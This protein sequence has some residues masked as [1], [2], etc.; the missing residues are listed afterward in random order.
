MATVL[1][2]GQIS[3]AGY[4]IHWPDLD[5][6]LSTEGLLRGAPAAAESVRTQMPDLPD[7]VIFGYPQMWEEVDQK[8]HDF[9]TI[10]PKLNDALNRLVNAAYDPITKPQKA[11]LNLATLSMIS[12]LE[13]VT[14]V[15]N[16][17][18]QGGLKILRSMLE[19]GINA[20]YLR[21]NPGE[22][23]DFI[24]WYWI[25]HY[26][27]LNYIRDHMP[28][29]YAEL[30][31]ENI[32][33]SEAEYNRVKPR[34]E[35]ETRPGRQKL[36]DSWCSLNLADRATR[37]DFTEE[38]KLIYPLTSRL[39]HGSLAGM[40]LHYDPDE[41][42]HRLAV[43]PSLEW[44]GETLICGHGIALRMANTFSQAFGVESNPPYAELERDYKT[45]WAK[46]KKEIP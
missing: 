6:D 23:D 17:L 35:Y 39:F 29:A 45:V 1:R 31:P 27:E 46:K 21:R 10:L 30:T 43:P 9:F 37:T 12:M 20:E 42:P 8:Y 41:D 40:K 3:G 36:R 38:Y 2:S 13:L 24:E 26:K 32:A 15:G 25:E 11:I 44:S 28:D 18:A 16:G 14:L 22:I 19:Y 34:F 7:R 33:K 5:E 4:G